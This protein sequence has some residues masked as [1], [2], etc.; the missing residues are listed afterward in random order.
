MDRR[1]TSYLYFNNNWSTNENDSWWTTQILNC[2]WTTEVN[3]IKITRIVCEHFH[4][5]RYNPF[6][7][8]EEAYFLMTQVKFVEKLTK[9]I[10]SDFFARYPRS[11]NF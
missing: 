3:G 10:L 5:D 1:C 11:E 9:A 2:M 8:P 4:H 6:L 7:H